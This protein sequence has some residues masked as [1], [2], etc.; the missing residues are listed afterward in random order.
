[1]KVLVPLTAGLVVALA[2]AS[3]ATAA[4]F[5]T[6]DARTWL[7]PS[8]SAAINQSVRSVKVPRK[9]QSNGS[10]TDQLFISN[11]GPFGRQGA[12]F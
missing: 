9:V 6:R 11:Y 8:R 7:K 10:Y 4:D 12:W 2:V 5:D 1:M 3:A